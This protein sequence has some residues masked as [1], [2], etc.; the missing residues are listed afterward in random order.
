[1]LAEGGRAA[2]TRIARAAR[3]LPSVAALERIGKP[4]RRAAPGRELPSTDDRFRPTAVVRATRK[5]P[6]L[7]EKADAEIRSSWEWPASACAIR[8]QLAFGLRRTIPLALTRGLAIEVACFV[9]EA[10]TRSHGATSP[11]MRSARKSTIIL[12]NCG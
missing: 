4:S 11:L 12:S 3:R 10:I 2:H 7:G 9:A 5:R 8:R 6:C 1:M